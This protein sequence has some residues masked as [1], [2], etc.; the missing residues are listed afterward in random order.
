MNLSRPAFAEVTLRGT[1]LRH[2]PGTR[3]RIRVC[4]SDCGFPQHV[5]PAIFKPES[6]MI[7]E[8]LDPG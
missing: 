1:L 5:I 6:R 2:D 4:N 8:S 3:P 7:K